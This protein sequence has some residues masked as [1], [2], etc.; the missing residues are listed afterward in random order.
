MIRSHRARRH[1]P[2]LRKWSCWCE[3]PQKDHWVCGGYD[4]DHADPH[5]PGHCE[6]CGDE[7]CRP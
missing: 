1:G 4:G 5:C 7:R 3:H 2:P 6:K